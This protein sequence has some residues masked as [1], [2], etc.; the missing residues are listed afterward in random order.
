MTASAP[1]TMTTKI[2]PNLLKTGQARWTGDHTPATARVYCRSHICVPYTTVCV[3]SPGPILTC[4]ISPQFEYPVCQTSS[5]LETPGRA[6][7]EDV[8]RPVLIPSWLSSRRARKPASG[9]CG[10]HRRIRYVSHFR[11]NLYRVY[12]VICDPITDS[13][14][15]VTQ[16][17]TTNPMGYSYL[18]GCYRDARY[19]GSSGIVAPFRQNV[20]D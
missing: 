9:G 1:M 20:S 8:H 6:V 5:A 7:S 13:A 16:S 4:W 10:T 19:D 14:E 12:Y 15:D 2:T 3:H 18:V 17:R 11:L